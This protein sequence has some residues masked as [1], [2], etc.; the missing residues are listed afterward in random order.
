MKALITEKRCTKCRQTKELSEFNSKTVNGRPY[1][2]SECKTCEYSRQAK[3]PS[4]D[5]PKAAVQTFVVQL[6]TGGSVELRE[7]TVAGAIEKA[8][9]M[10]FEPAGAVPK[11][12]DGTRTKE[13]IRQQAFRD[14][15]KILRTPLEEF[16]Q[17]L[18]GAFDRSGS[19][20]VTREIDELPEEP[21]A[22]LLG[23]KAMLD[24]RTLVC[25]RNM[26]EGIKRAPRVSKEA[27][28][29]SV[30]RRL[31]PDEQRRM[32]AEALRIGHRL[33]PQNPTEFLEAWRA[34]STPKE[35]GVLLAL[36]YGDGKETALPNGLE[37]PE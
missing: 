6:R 23:C 37:V 35:L 3:A 12:Q 4:R 27:Y 15:T 11:N 13:A 7:R 30:F 19:K 16:R 17:S 10:G 28:A 29:L 36:R 31:K 1:L 22:F 20:A 14:K 9:G 34:T 5:E 24:A 21:T 33:R 18:F 32:T 8:K 25:Y 2:R 26:A